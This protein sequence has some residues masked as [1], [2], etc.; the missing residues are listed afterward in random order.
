[1]L[2][3][4]QRNAFRQLWWADTGQQLRQGT[5]NTKAITDR[6]PQAIQCSVRTALRHFK[7]G[8]CFWFG[9]RNQSETIYGQENVYPYYFFPYNMLHSLQT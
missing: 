8:Q 2:L 4:E 7:P 5:G 9:T 6:L 3:I 1:M